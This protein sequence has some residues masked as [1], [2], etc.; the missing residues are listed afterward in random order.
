MAGRA[1]GSSRSPATPAFA[2]IS[3]SSTSDGRQAVLMDAPPAAR[4]SAAVRRGRRM[5]RRDR[6]VAHH[7]LA[8]DLDRGLLLLGDFG[9]DRLRERLDAAPD[10]ER[11]LYELATDVLVHLH[12]HPPM[13]GLPAARARPVARR[14]DAVSRLVCPRRR[15]RGRP[16]RLSRRLDRPACA[17]RRRRARPG[18]RAARL[19]CRKCHAGRR[20]RR[21]SRISACSI[22]RTRLPATRPTILPRCSKMP[23]ATSI[24]RSSA[25]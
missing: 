8:R 4:G 7:I 23:A 20:P 17:D 12:A 14:T 15:H 6:S 9:D 21:A 18:H 5:S 10:R 13:D 16:R 1:R 3:A 24:R 19:P 11:E 22:S 25:R 2:A